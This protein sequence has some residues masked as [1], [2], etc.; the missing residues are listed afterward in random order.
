MWTNSKFLIL[1]RSLSYRHRHLCMYILC[2]CFQFHSQLCVTNSLCIGKCKQFQLNIRI[3]SYVRSSNLCNVTNKS[4]SMATWDSRCVLRVT[5][6]QSLVDCIITMYENNCHENHNDSEF[7]EE[8][9]ISHDSEWNII[10]VW[11]GSHHTWPYM[12]VL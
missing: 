7:S 4:N 2:M 3:N 6:N 12:E 10:T 8:N 9:W 1:F 11:D 5:R